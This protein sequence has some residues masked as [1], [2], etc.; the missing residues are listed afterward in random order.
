[1]FPPLLKGGTSLFA[2]SRVFPV[3]C[4]IHRLLLRFLSTVLLQV[5]RSPGVAGPMPYTDLGTV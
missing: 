3:K 5:E 4:K 1:M 2:L